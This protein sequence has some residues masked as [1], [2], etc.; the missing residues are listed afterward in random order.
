MINSHLYHSAH[1]NLRTLKTPVVLRNKRRK[2]ALLLST[3][4]LPSIF[5]ILLMVSCAKQITAQTPHASPLVTLGSTENVL[6]A[7]RH[8]EAQPTLS[9]GRSPD[10]VAGGSSFVKRFALRVSRLFKALVSAFGEGESSSKQSESIA[11][12]D[13][14]FK[15]K[16]DG[17]WLPNKVDTVMAQPPGVASSAGLTNRPLDKTVE[18][19]VVS[20]RELSEEEQKQFEDA[21]GLKIAVR[22]RLSNH[23]MLPIYYFALQDSILPEGYQLFRE[24]GK[25]NWHSRPPR[26]VKETL[27]EVNE[28]EYIWLEL[29]PGK[30]Q[31]FDTFDWSDDNEEHA[32]ST[33]VKSNPNARPVEIVTNAFRPIPEKKT[34]IVGKA[35]LPKMEAIAAKAEPNQMVA[36]TS[37]Q[38]PVKDKPDAYIEFERTGHREPLYARESE[39]GIWLRLHNNTSRSIVL[40]KHGVP[41]EYY[42]D[43]S[44]IYSVFSEGQDIR[45]DSCHPC[46]AISLEPGRSL[47]FSLPAE[48]L[49]IGRSLRIEFSYSG[50]N[51]RKAN[52]GAE[53][54]HYIYFHASD[55]PKGI[56]PQPLTDRN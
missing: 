50:E 10:R 2:L 20:Q 56:S 1:R 18:F 32:F 43:A 44:L 46:S 15:V 22:L 3:K 9:I 17:S 45:P 36:A 48:H 35:S 41:S 12:R 42:G 6:S 31:E 49:S 28:G 38:F 24:V 8:K 11:D 51:R 33:F 47:L 30:S 13:K 21:L 52:A 27:P 14:G 25:D 23:G 37:Q 53:T 55:L 54:N 34:A 5:L 26:R 16:I 39:S 40:E 29:A 4:R 7:A 19:S